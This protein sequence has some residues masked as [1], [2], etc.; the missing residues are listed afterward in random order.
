MSNNEKT[1]GRDSKATTRVALITARKKKQNCGQDS[2]A[3][4]TQQYGTH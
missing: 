1:V 4:S 2:K 3:K